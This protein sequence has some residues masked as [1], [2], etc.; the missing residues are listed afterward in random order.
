VLRS[1][2]QGFCSSR[3]GGKEEVSSATHKLEKRVGGGS[4]KMFFSRAERNNAVKEVP[5]WSRNIPQGEL[6][7]LSA[8][9]EIVKL[10]GIKPS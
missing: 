7:G 9:K 6:P 5:V 10:K 4:G 3:T 8:R 1:E 2:L